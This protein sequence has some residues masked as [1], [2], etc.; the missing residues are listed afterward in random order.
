[1][2]FLLVSPLCVSLSVNVITPEPLEIVSQNFHGVILWSK[3]RREIRTW[4]YRGARVAFNVSGVLVILLVN[5]VYSMTDP[6]RITIVKCV[7]HWCCQEG[8]AVQLESLQCFRRVHFTCSA[9][10]LFMHLC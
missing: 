3:G 1:M 5:V 4:L 8:Y 2:L 9:V 10:L 7:S 6:G